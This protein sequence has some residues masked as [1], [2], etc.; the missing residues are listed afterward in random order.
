MHALL[1]LISY[2]VPFHLPWLFTPPFEG[3]FS[4]Q[5]ALYSAASGGEFPTF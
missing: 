3:T 5:V 1:A 4:R 2:E